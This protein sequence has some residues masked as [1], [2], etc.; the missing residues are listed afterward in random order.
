MLRWS[1]TLHMSSNVCASNF[2]SA[3]VSPDQL[4][5]PQF[6]F[7]LID[8]ARAL[9]VESLIRFVLAWPQSSS[10]CVLRFHVLSFRVPLPSSRVDDVT[11][12]S[13]T[14]LSVQSFYHQS[15]WSLRTACVCCSV[16]F[17]FCLQSLCSRPCLR[18]CFNPTA[19]I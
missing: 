13:W 15:R 2:K 18:G 7:L 16:P 4:R 11:L 12:L 6:S 1:A 8:S 9:S 5:V 14:L 17:L 10:T 3:S 19:T